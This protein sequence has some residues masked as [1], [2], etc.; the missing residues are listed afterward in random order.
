MIIASLKNG[1]Y[2]YRQDEYHYETLNFDELCWIILIR[3]HLER[4]F[5]IP[6][7]RKYIFF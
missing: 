4:C 6:L 2:S 7:I 5:Y 3:H 1:I